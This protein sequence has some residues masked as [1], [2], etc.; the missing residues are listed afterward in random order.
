MSI[1]EFKI[2]IPEEEILNLQQVMALRFTFSILNQ[3]IL[4][5]SHC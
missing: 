3:K 2:E 5:Q 4:G 1:E